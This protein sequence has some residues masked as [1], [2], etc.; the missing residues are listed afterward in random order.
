MKTCTKC[1]KSKPLTEFGK[2]GLGYKSWCKLCN[3]GANSKALTEKRNSDSSFRNKENARTAQWR[4]D[5]PAAR[6]DYYQENREREREQNRKWIQQNRP[7]TTAEKKAYLKKWREENREL[8]NLYQALRKN[9]IRA[10]GGN[11]TAKEWQDLCS[12]YGNVCLKCGKSG[13]TMDHI[14]PVSKGGRHEIDNLQ[15]LCGS[16]NSS[17]GTKTI[18][19]RS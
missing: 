10:N 11:V 18:D 7:W 5:N 2:R 19:Y 16:C 8:K 12:Y 14:I 6:S 9:R 13:V 1:K 3:S 15:P 17:K 4:K